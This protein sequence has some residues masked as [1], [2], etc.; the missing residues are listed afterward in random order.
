MGTRNKKENVNREFKEALV[1]SHVPVRK[2]V[3]IATSEAKKEFYV[4]GE[5]REAVTTQFGGGRA[6]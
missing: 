3:R 2:R 4:F 6:S 1:G 5:G